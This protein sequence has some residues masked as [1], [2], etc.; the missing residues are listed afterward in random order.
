[1]AINLG[2]LHISR[3]FR[4]IFPH[5]L[6]GSWPL[7]AYANNSDKPFHLFKKKK[8]KKKKKKRHQDYE[9]QLYY[10]NDEW[11]N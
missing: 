5:L 2:I 1:M 9:S 8:K 3:V 11:F 4:R 6:Y 7:T 10:H